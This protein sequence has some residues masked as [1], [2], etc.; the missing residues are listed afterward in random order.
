MIKKL[1]SIQLNCR[2]AFFKV[3]TSYDGWKSW[4]FSCYESFF[5]RKKSRISSKL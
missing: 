4:D 5:H 3:T 2:G 1:R